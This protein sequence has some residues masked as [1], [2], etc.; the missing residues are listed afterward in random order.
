M[1]A[2]TRSVL[3]GEVSGTIPYWLERSQKG[4]CVLEEIY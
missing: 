1:E 3:L 2:P 4:V